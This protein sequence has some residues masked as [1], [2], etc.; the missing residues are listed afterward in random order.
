MANPNVF[1]SLSPADLGQFAQTIQSSNPYGIAGNALGNAQFDMS[2]WSAP[3]QGATAFG[4]A[5]LSGILGNVARQNTASQ[6]SSVMQA[7]P[8]LTTNP[9]GT[10]LP[11]G[12]DSTA[13]NMLRG[14]S[15]LNLAQTQ[16]ASAAKKTETVGDLLKTVLSEGV[17]TGTITPEAALE[18]AGTGKL[19]AG[20]EMDLSKNP[21]SPQYKLN[22][23]VGDIERK[24]TETL[25]TGTAAKEAMN[26][27]RAATN[28]L[29]A[30]KKDNP[31][32]AST[33]IFEFAKLQDPTGTVREGDEL[34]VSDPGGPL[35]QLARTFNEIQ[36]KGKLTAEGK[37]AMRELVPV[38]QKNTFDQYN[39]IKGGFLEAAKQYG[40]SPE[41]IQFVKPTDLS[42]YLAEDVSATPAMSE[43]DAAL[44]RKGFN[45]DGTP[46]NK[47][48]S[49]GGSIFAPQGRS[50]LGV[51]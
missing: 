27:N 47:P 17:K 30:V 50:F 12:V 38:L 16:A 32:A 45:P 36:Q 23:D 37:K 8:S 11:E 39:Q 42:S 3:T 33:A 2:T 34:R 41:R 1:G 6:L 10:A 48:A 19:P 40:A 14:T 4:K 22:K 21:N 43:I 25:L 31:L 51:K 29:E 28:I 46:M 49:S 24:Y 26:I 44:A 5:F 9:M 15:A 35:G 20:Q 13:F 7:L 18:A